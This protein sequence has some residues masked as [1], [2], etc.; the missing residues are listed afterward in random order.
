MSPRLGPSAP[1]SSMGTAEH[2]LPAYESLARLI[3]EIVREELA[4][5][6]EGLEQLNS[7]RALDRRAREITDHTADTDGGRSS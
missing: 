1:S 7:E 2:L 3:R 4:P 5:V 6:I